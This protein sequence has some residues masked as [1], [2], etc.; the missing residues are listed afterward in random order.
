SSGSAGPAGNES[1]TGLL[2]MAD[3]ADDD[4][5]PDSEGIS[6]HLSIKIASPE[7]STRLN[8]GVAD[9][10]YPPSLSVDP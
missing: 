9:Q 8:D 6:E 5:A 3:A 1:D 7:T 10:E 2:A 4:I